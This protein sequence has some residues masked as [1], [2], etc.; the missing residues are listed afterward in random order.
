MTQHNIIYKEN[1]NSGI[2]WVV[3]LKS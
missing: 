3:Y 2:I 1:N